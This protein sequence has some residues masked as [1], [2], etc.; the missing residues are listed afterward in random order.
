M[1]ALILMDATIY[2]PRDAEY[3][4]L[5]RSV[6][7]VAD[8]EEEARA[9]A[10]DWVDDVEAQS[11]TTILKSIPTLRRNPTPLRKWDIYAEMLITE[12]GSPNV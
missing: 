5:T 10:W 9:A 7:I 12:K 11:R 3:Q 8:S 1:T 2:P 6:S 4:W